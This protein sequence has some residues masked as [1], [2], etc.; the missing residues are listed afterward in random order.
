MS[1]TVTVGDFKATPH[2]VELVNE[3]LASG[4]LSYGPKTKAFEQKWARLHDSRS[5]AFCNSGTSAL[6]VAVQALKEK[7]GW[8]DG[9][10]VIV[11]ATTFVATANVVLH[12]RLTPV[13]VDV[14]P[15]TYTLDPTLLPAAV[16]A[17]TRAVIPVHL[18]GL[19]ADMPA[20]GA[21]AAERG[22]AV[23]EDACETA[24]VAC[25]GRKVGSLGDVGCFSTYM[26][27]YVVTG[28]GGLATTSDPDLAARIRSLMNHGRDGIYVSIDDD[29]GLSGT[30][31]K[32]V[33]SRRFRFTSVGH[34]FRAT[35]L[36]AALGLAQLDHW[37][38]TLRRR[39]AV[40]ARYTAGLRHLAGRL[41]LPHAPAG[42]EHAFMMYPLRTRTRKEKEALTLHLEEN[43]VETRDLLPL[44]NQ[45]CYAHLGDVR[46]GNPV[47]SNLVD[48][49]FYVGCHQYLTDDDADHVVGLISDFYAEGQ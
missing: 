37:E 13:F 12:N 46:Q 9:D 24:F 28:V 32:E 10:E 43:G 29:D 20:I 7:H 6:Q 42:R 14:D 48:L 11:P 30:A 38:A 40:A 19:P 34:S 21:A 4:R 1:R 31:L 8:A 3:V 45:P 39:Q 15:F 5:A 22:L 49:A 2:M 17:R 33:M 35:E 44:V 41:H 16:T 36:E 47:A 27:H 18:C 23:V 26:A 25:H